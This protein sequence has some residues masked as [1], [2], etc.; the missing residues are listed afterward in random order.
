MVLLRNRIELQIHPTTEGISNAIRRDQDFYEHEILDYLADNYYIMS[1]IVDVGANIGNHT[2]FFDEYLPC[3]TVIA[4][5]PVLRNF[6][7]LQRNTG[8]RQVVRYFGAASDRFGTVKMLVKED[9][10]GTPRVSE[11]GECEVPCFPIDS[12]IF[13]EP[14]SLMKI[15]VE[16]HEPQVIAGAKQT[17]A[18]YHPLILIEDWDH[19]YKELLPGY[20]E[21]KYWKKYRTYLYEWNK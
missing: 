11:E 4:I 6:D 17:I 14:V 5:E 20:K 2:V 12:L 13:D 8:D 15:D 19:Q 16:Y 1:T 7:V 9:N 3:R 21:V 10:M 18:I